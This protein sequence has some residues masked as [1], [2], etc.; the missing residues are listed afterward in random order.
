[1]TDKATSDIWWRNAICYCLDVKTF[2]DSTGDG[3]GDL[4]GLTEHLAYLRELGVD[5]LWLMPCHPSP[6]R[7]DGYDVTDYYTVDP[8]IGTLG[9]F[10]ET[11]RTAH[12]LGIRVIMDLVVN[13][14]SIDHPWF[15]QARRD[16]DSPYR[17]FYLWST[18][19][20][21]DAHPPVFPGEQTETWTWDEEAQAYYF[22]H[23]YDFSPDLAFMHERVHD[24]VHK[25]L[26]FWLEL[27]VD[28]VRV[29]SLP[30]LIDKP[31][32]GESEDERHEHLEVMRDFLS[33]RRG[34]A[35]LLGEANLPR[36]QQL[37]FFGPL[38]QPR[39]STETHLLFDFAM[40]GA[41]WLALA[42]GSAEPVVRALRERPELPH[43]CAYAVFGRHHDELTFENVLSESEQHEVYD[44][45]DPDGVGRIYDRGLRRRTAS[46]L[47]GD[48]ERIR[49][50]LQ[51]VLSLPGMPIILYGDEIGLRDNLTLPA[52]L[53]PR[54]PMPWTVEDGFSTA[55]ED[56][57][58][59]PPADPR[60][61]RDATVAGQQY[62]DDSLWTDVSRAIRARR[63]SAEVGHGTC[64]TLPATDDAVL[65]LQ[66]DWLGKRIVILHNLSD[67][68]IERALDHD[69]L[70]DGPYRVLGDSP[71]P[72]DDPDTDRILHL[73][74]RESRWIR[75]LSS[76]AK[77]RI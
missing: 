8:R 19:R 36:D 33:R 73:G 61:G 11:V 28:G 2:A 3:W 20:P 29:D 22:H 69:T 34:S 10:V 55:P 76:T 21:P 39:E 75:V 26:G 56:Q 38:N 25:I 44:A 27:G 37:R 53:A 60:P 77:H 48:T 12:A 68:T 67:R 32:S 24:E 50:L 16:P 43:G 35:V 13:H 62:R 40:Q 1:M 52:R 49:L 14:T 31:G 57:W 51:L 74:P 18:D 41:L 72:Q 59:R 23:Y 47:Q 65:A 66:Y 45:F 54:V 58:I 5:C 9:D 42:R 46:L 70:P 64:R 6:L 15:Q 63:D 7:D 30:F 17:D 4:P 71:D